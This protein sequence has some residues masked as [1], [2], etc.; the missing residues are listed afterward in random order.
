MESKYYIAVNENERQGPFTAEQ[1][2]DKVTADTLVWSDKLD[3]WMPV[4]DVPE[5]WKS[6]Q[7][8]TTKETAFNPPQSWL[9]TSLLTFFIFSFVGGAIAIYFASKVDDTY[10]KGDTKLARHYSNRAQL[11]VYLGVIIGLIARPSIIYVIYL[12]KQF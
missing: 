12:L 6:I 7:P 3:N 10:L 11:F 5:L 1:L 4:K 2:S 8:N 9:L